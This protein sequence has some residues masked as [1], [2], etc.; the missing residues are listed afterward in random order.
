MRSLDWLRKLQFTPTSSDHKDDSVLL[1]SDEQMHFLNGPN[2]KRLPTL[3]V[4]EM[5]K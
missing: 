1:T 4:F 3:L 5:I 2:A